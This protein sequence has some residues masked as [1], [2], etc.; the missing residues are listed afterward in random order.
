[1]ANWRPENTVLTTIGL[2]MLSKAQVGL[3]RLQIT[4]IVTSDTVSTPEANR[5]MTGSSST[6]P[7]KQ[8]CVLMSVNGGKPYSGNLA[9]DQNSGV[10]Q[11]TARVSNEYITEDTV[12][13]VRQIIVFMRLVDL[14]DTKEDMGE[15]PYMVAQTD[16]AEDYDDIPPFSSNPTAINYDLFIL[17]SGVASVDISVK[18]AGYVDDDTFNE[19]KTEITNIVNN[20]IENEVGQNTEGMTFQSWRPQYS[21]DN[22][23]DDARAWSKSSETTEVTGTKSAER[24]NNYSTNN[25]IAT[26]KDC[27]VEGSGNSSVNSVCSHLEGT[28]NFIEYGEKGCWCSHIE[29]RRNTVTDG[30][31]QHV[32]GENNQSS[33]YCSH[34][35]GKKNLNSNSSVSHVEGE[36]NTVRNGSNNHIGGRENILSGSDYTTMCGRQNIA[37]DTSN[38]SISGELN[39]AYETSHTTVSGVSNEVNTVNGANVSGSSNMSIRSDNVSVSGNSNRTTDSDNSSVSG[40]SNN[41]FESN[42]TLITGDENTASKSNR[43]TVSGYKNTVQNNVNNS[44]VSGNNN[45]VSSNRVDSC[46]DLIVSGENN[47]VT[48]S[49]HS[50]IS[51]CIHVLQSV[52]DSEIIGSSNTIY[53]DT[54]N[55][56]SFGVSRSSVSGINNS[57]TRTSDSVITGNMNTVQDYT[58]NTS[59]PGSFIETWCDL[60][61]GKNNEVH[62]MLD[63]VLTGFGNSVSNIR[64]SVISGMENTV[65]SEVLDGSTNCILCTGYKCVI[66]SKGF[67][68][69][70]TGSYNT[71]TGNNSS[72]LGT[73]NIAS[74]DEQVVLGHYNEEDT[75]NKYALIVGGGSRNGE[76]IAR[77]NILELDWFGNLYIPAL[78]TDNI[79]NSDGTNK[80]NAWNIADGTGENSVV[81]NDITNNH[82]TAPFTTAVGYNTEATQ[83]YA[84]SSGLQ[85]KAHGRA[86]AAFGWLNE[87]SGSYS[88]TSGSQNK[89]NSENSAAFGSKN[90]IDK[91]STNSMI[92]GLS[93]T[94]SSGSN[95]AMLASSDCTV[96]SEGFSIA[97]VAVIGG[98]YCTVKSK[99]QPNSN[100][101]VTGVSNKV[102]DSSASIISG[103]ENSV[104]SMDSI[105]SGTK[106]TVSP[107]ESGT[108]VGNIVGGRSNTVSVDYSL[109]VG[110]G[111]K[112]E[113]QSCSVLGS[114]NIDTEDSA[115][116][117]GCGSS[118]STRLN[119]LRVS[120]SGSVHSNSAFNSTGADASEWFEWKDGNTN[121]EDRRGLFVTLD[122]DK[123]VLADDNTKYIQG[124]IS[125]CPSFVGNASE[126]HWNNKFMKDVFGE[127]LYE[128]VTVPAQT[129]KEI[130]DKGEE[131]T[132]VIK[133]SHTEKRPILNP[134]Y[135]PTKEYLPRS[136][137]PEW[138]YVSC[139]GRLVV[140]DD[141]TCVQNGYCRPKSGGIATAS[142]TGFRVMKRID[143]THILVWTDGAVTLE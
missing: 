118:D 131:V 15:V 25:N 22:D 11:I 32:E 104:Y 40:Y 57:V 8:E 2:Q 142:E 79:F 7:Y 53:T 24:F 33:G 23:P 75:Q 65:S 88:F 73:N 109:V 74:G 27:H 5:S 138:S 68:V 20:I 69:F 129:I 37:T 99:N 121:V 70:V 59:I 81:A 95:I 134:E 63:S 62:G 115:F 38:S 55:T 10:S 41:L 21:S 126:D 43:S 101:I 19:F 6:I 135:D 92:S 86:S 107:K 114:Y 97:N 100:Y 82:A 117:V 133:E 141:G 103:A 87:S 140:V 127:V 64:D 18:T 113:K 83:D 56:K 119:G 1:M 139:W 71:C 106:N 80:F 29:G 52:K 105:V 143:D 3:G 137:R 122:G 78:Y 136:K 77:K 28:E 9:L 49:S 110:V 61:A 16:G 85:S 42:G 123:I 31:I 102:N 94:I 108:S 39:R 96:E 30:W 13:G 34:T 116:I 124:I 12:Y 45:S 67:P 4:K 17:H 125:A 130:S 14:T 91:N 84:F 58:P 112:S 111:L 46:T 90:N 72:V 66:S 47:K 93:N 50:V 89:V 44:V 60:I 26:G 76:N 98:K 128:E 36:F 120:K 132:I 54:T 51:G 48:D 35:E